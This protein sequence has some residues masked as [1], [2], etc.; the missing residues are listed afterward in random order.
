MTAARPMERRLPKPSTTAYRQWTPTPVRR[1]S[2]GAPL[3]ATPPQEPFTMATA[4]R[5]PPASPHRRRQPLSTPLMLLE[6]STYSQRPPWRSLTGRHLRRAAMSAAR[7]MERCLPKPSA[8]ASAPHYAHDHRP[9]RQDP[10]R[11]PPPPLRRPRLARMERRLPKPSA[12]ASAPHYAQPR[13]L[14]RTLT[15]RH[16]RRAAI[17]AACPWSGTSLNHPTTTLPPP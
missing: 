15:G 14:R 13:A 3:G 7:P 5:S 10:N 1:H 2:D 8:T 16:L 6:T 9:P 12:T 4:T 17:P 11:S